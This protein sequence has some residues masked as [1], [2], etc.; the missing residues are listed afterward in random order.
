MWQTFMSAVRGG[1]QEVLFILGANLAQIEERWDSGR[2]PSARLS[3]QH[4]TSL[5]CFY[6]FTGLLALL[7]H[8][9]SCIKSQEESVQI[10]PLGVSF[11]SADSL[12]RSCC[13][14]VHCPC[15]FSAAHLA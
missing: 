1:L 14:T 2:L 10:R 6:V 4:V 9:P 12:R 8:P 3:S 5:V 11:H 7:H 13:W 15:T